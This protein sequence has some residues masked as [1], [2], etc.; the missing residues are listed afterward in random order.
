MLRSRPKQY[1]K[2]ERPPLPWPGRQDFAPAS[3]CD[4]MGTAVVKDLTPRNPALLAL[5]KGRPC[6]FRIPG[7]CNHNP[8]T[9][10]ACHENEGKGMAIKASDARSAVGCSA[11]HEAYDRGPALRKVK[12]GWFAVAH[13]RQMLD[14]A[15]IVGDFSESPKNRKAAHWALCLLEQKEPPDQSICT[16]EAINSGVN[17]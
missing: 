17:P 14:W 1:T 16:S 12:R 7:I 3:R 9:C 2:P 5:A 15:R 13:A 10:V 6:M 4:S 8:A 11:C